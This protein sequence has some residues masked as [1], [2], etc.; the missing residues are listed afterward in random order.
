MTIRQCYEAFGGAYDEVLARLGGME[1]LITKLLH[2]YPDDTTCARLN[3]AM[4][5]GDD[6]EAFHAAHTLKGVALNLGFSR[7]ADVASTLTEALRPG[8]K[9][10]LT[11]DELSALREEINRLNAEILEVVAQLE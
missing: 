8:S 2:K 1:R 10:H 9:V 7:L 6:E 3:Q 5:E 11:R 4:D